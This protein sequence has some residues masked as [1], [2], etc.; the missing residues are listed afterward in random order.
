MFQLR[1]AFQHTLR[2]FGHVSFFFIFSI[3]TI[4]PILFFLIQTVLF[5]YCLFCFAREVPDRDA[6]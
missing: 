4:L 2:G 5:R 1:L 3:N 6:N